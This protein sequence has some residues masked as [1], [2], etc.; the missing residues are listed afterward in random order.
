[1]KR[2]QPWLGTFVEITA[3]GLPDALLAGA[4]TKAMDAIA[5]VHRLMSFHACDSDLYRLNSQAYKVPVTVH[6]WTYELLVLACALHK[7]TH[8]LFDCAIAGY[9]VKWGLL[10]DHFFDHLM[11]HD[12][13]VSTAS[14][15]SLAQADRSCASYPAVDVAGDDKHGCKAGGEKNRTNFSVMPLR[16]GTLCDV[17]LL[18]QQ[19]VQFMRPLQLDLGGIAKGFAVD[20]AIDVL[21]TA[22]VPKAMVNAGGDLRVLGDTPEPM[23]VRDTKDPR[24]LHYVGALAQG[25]MATSATYFSRTYYRGQPVSA[26]VDPNVGEACTHTLSCS[27]IAPTCAVADALTKALALERNLEA[28]YFEMYEAH[29]LLHGVAY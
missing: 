29:A 7:A 17:L 25:A 5:L 3:T 21:H 13:D 23:Y 12:V 18:P 10:P 8:G 27:V 20:R 9:L 2:C 28:P 6:P 4:L 16:S 22:G 19:Q 1:M 11:A 26:L 24:Q 14:I 15:E